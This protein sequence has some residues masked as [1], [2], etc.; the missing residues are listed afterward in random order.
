LSAEK[1][2]AGAR[3]SH[4]LRDHIAFAH[5]PISNNLSKICIVL[6]KN[7]REPFRRMQWQIERRHS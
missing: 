7:L 4:R 5:Q 2:A 1:N 6:F 3:D